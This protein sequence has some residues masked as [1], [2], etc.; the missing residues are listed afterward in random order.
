MAHNTYAPV[1]DTLVAENI[2]LTIGM[3]DILK[4][5]T[6]RASKNSITGLLG[7]NGAGKSTMLQSVFGARRAA[8][9]DVF[10]NGVKTRNP[11]TIQGL[12]NYL[13]QRPFL[14]GHLTA[15][16]LAQHFSV[17]TQGMLTHFPGLEQELHKPVRDLS[18][19]QLR[20]VSVLLI[21]LAPTRFT[22]LDEPFSHIMPLHIEKLCE[23]LIQQKQ[24][25]GIIITDHMYRPLLQVSDKLFLMREGKSIYMR[26]REDLVLHGYINHLE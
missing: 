19:G 25:K 4:G 20:L 7:R 2:F 11:Y 3:K 21:L 9:C 16:K 23:L 17:S 22:L 5:V 12:V 6:I 15:H 8:E 1:S 26:E 13:P 14:P 10:V 24:H 18:G